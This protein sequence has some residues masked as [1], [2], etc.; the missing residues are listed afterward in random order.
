MVNATRLEL[1]SMAYFKHDENDGTD[2]NIWYPEGGRFILNVRDPKLY[3]SSAFHATNHVERNMW[4]N[5]NRF[6]YSVK[7]KPLEQ[8][9]IFEKM[10]YDLCD[11]FN[12]TCSVE[13]RKIKCM[14]LKRISSDDKIHTKGGDEIGASEIYKNGDTTRTL[15]FQNSSFDQL[16]GQIIPYIDN[17]SMVTGAQLPL[18][19]GTKYTG[20]IDAEF[21]NWGA[22]NW[23]IAL[24]RKSLQKYGLDL[25]E[26]YR[27]MDVLVVSDDNS[28]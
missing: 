3:R 6:C 14:V 1:F 19:N 22:D 2:N 5:T 28:K 9:D 25:V 12:V 21:P 10:K 20:R 24:L 23:S 15:I 13:N 18:I 7:I 4:N 26:E 17:I 11:F 8:E 27:N 16:F